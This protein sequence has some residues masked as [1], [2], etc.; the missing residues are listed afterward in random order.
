VGFESMRVLDLSQ[1]FSMHTP[2]FASYDGPSI[3]WV[4]RLAFD[5]VGGQEITSTLH[6]GTHLDGPVHFWSAGRTIGELPLPWLVGS[7]VVVDLERM[8]VG[9]Y[10]LYG[11][12]HF[13]RWER[14][15]GLRVERDDIL[16]IHTGYHRFYNEN[17]VDRSQVDETRYFVRHPGPTRELAEWVLDRGVRWLA[18]DAGSA[19][20]PMNTVIRKIRPDEAEDAEAAIGRSLDEVFPRHD[21]QIMHTLLFPHDVIHI[22]NLGGQIDEVLDQ[23]IQFGCFPW[24]FVGG[25]AAF[26]RAVAFLE[27]CGPW[28]RTGTRSASPTCLRRTCWRPAASISA[29]PSRPPSR[30]CWPTAT[31]TCCSPTR[32]CRSSTR[33]RR[34]G[35]TASRRRC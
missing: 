35:S 26:C 31:A 8:G 13:E 14:E 20:H 30:R 12:E 7:A 3:K 33:R 9:D 27:G 11:P 18:V 21:L 16:I 29:W 24:K 34:S 23:R 25:E 22:E 6:V 17:W 1:D 10:Q 5:K 2:A 4:K 28:L 15:T 19:D 32:S